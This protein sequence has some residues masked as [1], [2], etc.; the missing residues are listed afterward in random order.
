MISIALSG[1]IENILRKM[2]DVREV[3][4]NIEKE[5]LISL[6]DEVYNAAKKKSLHLNNNIQ[7]FIADE[8]AINAFALGRKTIVI[9]RGLMAVMD[10]DKIKGILAHEFGHL[11]SSDT[12]IKILINIASTIYLWFI[13]ALRW[14]V[15]KVEISLKRSSES[16]VIIVGFIIGLIAWLLDIITMILTLVGTILLNYDYRQKEYKADRYAANLGY[17][18]ELLEALYELYEIQISDKKDLI[19]RYKA[20][21]P[22][23]AYRIRELEK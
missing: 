19:T 10:D 20:D 21:H 2:E 9:S 17:K 1:F 4:T 13:L 11:A 5:R 8:M 15:T 12:Q 14:I 22:R 3:A 7:L 18:T 6:F 16:G 23:I